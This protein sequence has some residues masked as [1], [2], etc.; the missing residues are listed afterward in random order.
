LKT[1]HRPTWLPMAAVTAVLM[2]VLAFLYAKTQHYGESDHF[3]HVALLRHVKQL[4]A[5]WELDVLKS[6]IGINRH[7]DPLA[8]SLTE[9]S[10]LLGK[11][12]SD[13]AD[14]L[15]D[16]SSE[17]VEASVALR[18]VVQE[19]ADLIERFKSNNSVLRNSLVFLP[20]AAQDVQQSLV[21]TRAGAPAAATRALA[22]VSKLLLDSM[23]YSQSA[24]DDRGAEIQVEL[25]RLQADRLLLA[26]DASDRLGI[27]SAHVNTVLREQKVVNDLLGRIA[28]VPTASRI[29]SISNLLGAEQQRAAEQ[30]RRYREY[31]LVFSAVLIGLFLYAAVK[32]IRSH[33]VINR[34]NKE[35]QNANETL[36][37]RVQERT[38]ELRQAQ[39]E[40]V[41]TARQAGMAEIATNVLHNVGNVLNSVNV[42]AGL[43]TS[44]V[45]ASK[46]QGLTRA[47]QLMNEH[48]DD[49]ETFLASDAKGRM[50]P[51]YLGQLAPVLVKEQQG[52]IEELTALTKSVDH[53]KE[54]IA[55]QQAYAG[56]S[57]IA[58]W[59]QIREL[60][61]DALRMNAGALARHQVVVVKEFSPVPDLPLD[62][63]RILQIL[64]NLI[65]NA[66]QAMEE[67]ADREHRLTLRIEVVQDR[68]LRI[69]VADNGVGIPPENLTRVF[70]HGFT[71]KKEGH[72]FGL[73]SAVVAAREMGGSLAVHSDGP[74][75]G[76]TFTLELPI[77]T[78]EEMP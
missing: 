48:A 61:E 45:R 69:A 13:V 47:V 17:L 55:T 20:T 58:E 51:G 41:T 44:S 72:G 3:E 35:L 28:V 32:L 37:Q 24:S 16:E 75:Q 57:S 46:I 70:A 9:L 22:S 5:Q 63:G 33:A 15:H 71:T 4:D 39:S 6:K 14:A 73:H 23:L 19:K 2:A 60:V 11:F 65:G 30:N 64:V 18:G 42:S 43:I 1:P 7:Y 27:F 8:D 67:L 34:V 52:V 78:T 74:G 66:K 38:S 50:L 21:R 10:A 40:L 29:D 54:I 12:E 36:E 53:I 49:L 59:T 68:T 76:A 26:A 25:D 62:K 77:K 56:A 31:L